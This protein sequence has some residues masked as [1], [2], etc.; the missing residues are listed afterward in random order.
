MMLFSLLY[1]SISSITQS[2]FRIVCNMHAVYW[3]IGIIQET[4]YN[5]QSQCVSFASDFNYRYL[6][7]LLINH[8]YVQWIC[9]HLI[10]HI[11]LYHLISAPYLGT[12]QSTRNT[13]LSANTVSIVVTMVELHIHWF[14]YKLSNLCI[15][16]KL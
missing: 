4:N 15:K 16:K 11:K 14:N 12:W 7:Y 10:A 8:K 2:F 6:F 3:C 13:R 5:Y 9:N 1:F